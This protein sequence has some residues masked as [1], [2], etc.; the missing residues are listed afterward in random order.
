MQP[1]HPLFI[2][3]SL[4][5]SHPYSGGNFLGFQ[6]FWSVLSVASSQTTKIQGYKDANS[7]YAFKSRGFGGEIGVDS[8]PS[9]QYRHAYKYSGVGLIHIKN[10]D[11]IPSRVEGVFPPETQQWSTVTRLLIFH[12]T[13]Q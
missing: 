10:L 7:L 11:L 8:H 13:G 4:S 2:D 5:I 1:H 3:R 12:H 9:R 6:Y